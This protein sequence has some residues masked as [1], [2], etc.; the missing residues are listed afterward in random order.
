MQFILVLSDLLCELYGIMAVV[1]NLL[2]S[3]HS[4]RSQSLLL[5]VLVMLLVIAA[6]GTFHILVF[7][8]FV[9]PACQPG[10]QCTSTIQNV[11]LFD[12]TIIRRDEKFITL[13]TNS[14]TSSLCRWTEYLLHHQHLLTWLGT[15]YYP[16]VSVY[17]SLVILCK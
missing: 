17:L 2:Q 8:L 16:L 15:H 9:F 14:I 4:C 6:S 12:P 3:C 11:F 10:E 1:N 5:I 13:C 7:L